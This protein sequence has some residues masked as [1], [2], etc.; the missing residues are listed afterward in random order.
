M[1][2]KYAIFGTL[3]DTS[4]TFVTNDTY[5]LGYKDNKWICI[6]FWR[7]YITQEINL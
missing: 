2:E 6:L 5:L 7:K 3:I 4:F 1:K